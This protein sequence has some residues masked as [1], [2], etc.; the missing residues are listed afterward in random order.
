[1]L[2]RLAATR[3]EGRLSKRRIFAKGNAAWLKTPGAFRRRDDAAAA[4]AFP[5]IPTSGGGIEL[6]VMVSVSPAPGG[7]LPRRASLFPRA[8]LEPAGDVE[9]GQAEAEGV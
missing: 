4:A 5:R 8:G 1:M 2:S 3:A 9:R 6:C 7:V